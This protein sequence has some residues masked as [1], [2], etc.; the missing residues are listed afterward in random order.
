[1][2]KQRIITAVLLAIVLATGLIFLPVSGMAALFGLIVLL[3]A[4][5]WSA[6]SGLASAPARLGYTALIGALLWAGMIWCDLLGGANNVQLQ[7]VQDLV[8]LGCTWWAIALLWVKGYPASAIVWGSRVMRLMMGILTLV[9]AWLALVY[10]R[11]HDNG[12]YWLL[13]LIAIVSSADIGAYFS[14]RAWGRA[15]LAPAVSP[16]KSWAGLV[17]GLLSSSLLSSLLWWFFRQEHSYGSVIVVTL[18]TVM[19]SVLGDLLESMVKRH[20]GVKDSG[21]L[22]PGHGGV[23][24]RADS[25]TAAA[26]VFALSLL[27]LGW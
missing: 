18:V 20:R 25:L 4:W 6:L 2:L 12:L 7:R 9:P 3:G 17:G 19:A 21:M 11:G 1:M 24:D 15:K 10:L 13:V 8:A 5:E 27:L 22:L 26:P 16:G 23:L 14:G